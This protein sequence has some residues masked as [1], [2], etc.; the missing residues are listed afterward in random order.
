V[1]AV[2]RHLQDLRRYPIPENSLP[3]GLA[4]LARVA[5]LSRA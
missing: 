4:L 2:D 5:G 3:R 1:N